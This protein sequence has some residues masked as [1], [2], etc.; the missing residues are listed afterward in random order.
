M[1]P[2]YLSSIKRYSRFFV[3]LAISFAIAGL[4]LF[5]GLTPFLDTGLYDLFMRFRVLHGQVRQNPLITYIDLDDES[6]K[7]LGANLDTRKAYAD[8]LEVLHNAN[9][10]VLLDFLFRYGKS[11]DEAFVNAVKNSRDPVIA[12]LAVDKDIAGLTQPDLTDSEKQMLKK[13]VWHIKVKNPGSIPEART[14][15]LPF[16]A[17]GAEAGQLGHVNAEPD[18]DG[19]Y[20][21]V[22]LLYRWD[23]G[24]IPSLPLAA[25]VLYYGLPVESIELNAGHYLTLPL[26]E[27][28]KINIPIDEKGNM[29]VPYTETAKESFRHSMH[30]IVDAKTNPEDLAAIRKGFNNHIAL[31]AEISTSQKDFGPTSFERLYPLSGIHA[32]VLSSIL[33]GLDK[34]SFIDVSSLH[35]KVLAVLLLMIIAFFCIIIRRDL[36]FHLGFLFALMI[37]SGVTF[38]RWNYNAITPWYAFPALFFFLLWLSAYLFRLLA[39]YREQVL[40]KNALSRYFPRAL[41]ERIMREGKTELVPAHKELTILFSDISGFTKWSSTK[42]PEEVHGFLNDY[43][44]S[45][46]GILFAHNGTVDKFM[47]D[48][49]LAFF[50]DP[51]EMQD[52][53]E[54]CVRAAIAMQDK[55]KELAEKWRPLV[56]IDLKVRIGINSGKVIV[57]NLG[58]KTRIEYTVIGAAVNLAQRME[59][60]APPGGILVTAEACERVKGLFSFGEKREVQVKGYDENIEA[61]EIRGE[62]P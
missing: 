51:F 34:R 10:S 19:V 52:H 17:L 27:E 60:N 47:G 62:L 57:G 54:R 7:D 1:S 45:M 26:S 49:I 40:L 15:I 24:F 23:D 48:G 33:D 43:L 36:Y 11:D 37:F 55:I 59:S 50:G 2:Q 38:Y 61:Y 8:A 13:H 6:I 35:Y 29:L 12:V 41:A 30:T 9:A 53:C 5:S 58:S 44:E 18:P 16:S 25:A 28:E 46:A 3:S 21:R 4:L 22:P 31:I 14:F 20:R 39:R 32:S 56:G 42:S